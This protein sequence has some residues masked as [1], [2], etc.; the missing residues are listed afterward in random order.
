[1]GKPWQQRLSV[2][3]ASMGAGDHLGAAGA[4]LLDGGHCSEETATLL[5]EEY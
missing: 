3:P 2:A 4:G 1:M 5:L